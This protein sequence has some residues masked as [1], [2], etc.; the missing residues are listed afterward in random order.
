[1]ADTPNNWGPPP[2]GEQVR[3]PPHNDEAERSMLGAVFV[4][5]RAVDEV[6][7]LVQPENLY[8]EPHR[9]IFRAMLE[10]HGRGEAIDVITLADYL[11]AEGLL[12]AVGGANALARLS[13]EVPSATNVSYYATIVKRKA[14]LRAF[15]AAA[16]TLIDECYSDVSD[17][18]GFMDRAEAE[19]FAITRSGAQKSYATMREVIR[20]AFAQI[21]ALY[22]KAEQVTGVP[23]GF[24]DLDEITAGWQPSD[25]II[26]AA[27]PAMGKCL[28]EGSR[29]MLADGRWEPI[30]DL[31]ARGEARVVTLD[32]S[33]RFCEADVSAFVDDGVKPAFRVTTR[34]GRRVDATAVHPLLTLS[35]WRSVRDLEVG[36]PIAV[37]RTLP[38]FG[39]VRP[40]DCEAK[41]CGYLLGDG[42]FCSGTPTFRSS[43]EALIDDF[44]AA[45]EAFGGLEV[46][47]VEDGEET[48]VEVLGLRPWLEELGIWGRTDSEKVVPE[49]IFT[50]DERSVASFLNR[51][52]ASGGRVVTVK[53]VSVEVPETGQSSSVWL[54]G[55]SEA[56]VRQVSHLLL[57]FG[58]C[59]RLE[60]RSGKCGGW[61]L[62]IDTSE[63]SLHRFVSRIGVVSK[64]DVFARVLAREVAEERG[65]E[66]VRW[67][68]I[69]SIEPLGMK[70]VYDL[71][72]PETHNFVAE[73]V[74]VHNTAI[75]LNMASH[76]ALERQVPVAFFSLEMSNVQLALRMLCS[77]S[78]VDQGKMRTGRLTEQE[79]ARLLKGAKSLSES[80]IFL[81][82]TPAL[83]IME[84]RSKARQL[85]A[86][87]DIGIIFVDYLQL[88]KAPGRNIGSRE[89]EISEISRNLKGIAKELNVPVIAL[90]QL[91][92]GVEQRADKRPMNSDLRESG[93]IEQDA[94]IISFI[95]R[96]EVYNP[97]SEDKGLAEVILGKH[98]NGG[99]GT[100]KLRFF[101]Q[102][103]RFENLAPGDYSEP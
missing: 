33:M 62:N 77:E 6:S 101:G 79:W 59:S 88:M 63:G 30:E 24:A 90:A 75:T 61:R 18:D 93:A 66:D 19:L 102:F 49:S 50:W 4:D 7:A 43:D 78:R 82:D 60:R 73:D 58:V 56:F 65:Q 72:V 11:S 8:R 48:A 16:H 80:K 3:T 26:L 21:E 84:L 64:E 35:G 99:L 74:C 10:L 57:R 100:V 31:H 32:R 42:I 97:E 12:D 71:T 46:R 36:T 34:S 45:A 83:P 85:K 9:H 39:D 54:R 44:I 76:A 13:H 27:R 51:L 98:R 29:V 52:F 55:T 14:S 96:D 95:Y 23:S 86:E 38:F 68:P 20:E 67:D 70:Q 2:M 92:R 28:V 15:I 1:M 40:R 81:D 91:N 87:H 53:D 103:T 89:Q 17:F 22:Q 37:P 69:V 5:N 41:L 94:D 47:R 25:L